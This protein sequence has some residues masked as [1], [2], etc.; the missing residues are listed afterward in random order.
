[1][2]IYTWMFCFLSRIVSS[3]DLMTTPEGNNAALN[4]RN[5]NNIAYKNETVIDVSNLAKG[6]YLVKV[7]TEEGSASKTLIKN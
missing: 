1:M 5:N 4:T 2:G 3:D 7:K 6:M